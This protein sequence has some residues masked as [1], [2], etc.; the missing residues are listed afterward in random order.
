MSVSSPAPTS[1][2]DVDDLETAI[3]E[4]R[5][6]HPARAYLIKVADETLNYRVVE[7]TDPVP[8][9]RQ[10][11][12]A[13][14]ARPVDEFS[15]CAVLPNGEFEDLRLDEP[16]D[17]RGHGTERFIYF[18]TDRLFKF[19]IDNKQQEWGKALIT[20]AILR[21]LAAVGPKYAIYLEVRGGQ[22]VEIGDTDPV[23][24]SKPGIERFI[25]V[26]KET[27]E[28]LTALPEADRNYL[29]Q[30]GIAHR[31]VGHGGQVGVVIE[32][33]QLPPHKYDRDHVDLLIILPGG[34]PD[35]CPDMFFMDPW[36]RLAET[37]RYPERADHAHQFSG[38]S[39]Q[40]WSRHC[41]EWRPGIDGLH[42]MIAR[43]R[44]AIERAR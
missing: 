20:G 41:G 26:I 42:T 25:T 44:Y 1:R 17:L 6:L 21:R 36:V 11:L 39:W 5:P 32:G 33:F 18:R 23:D 38:Q 13:A 3:R 27:T 29:E 8:L 22:D 43:A 35:A 14:G 15:V 10:V 24:L 9:G 34:Y 4:D 28:G 19:T 31:L 7:V 40:R 2:P 12:D 16:F 37:G 30:H